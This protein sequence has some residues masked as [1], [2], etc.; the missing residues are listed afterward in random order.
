MPKVI[1]HPD[2]ANEIKSSYEWY[3]GRA[4]GLGEDFLS[5]LESAY[6]TIVELPDTW[7]KLSMYYRRF[8]LGKFPF[9]II[10]REK[11]DCIFVVAV[12]HNSRKPGYWKNR[13]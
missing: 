10:Y 7:P 8:L 11:D 2:V 5:E 13:G 1:F 9:S 3:Q 6:Q 4:E 12:M